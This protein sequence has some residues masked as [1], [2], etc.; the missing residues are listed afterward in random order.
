MLIDNHNRI[1][2]YLRLA[3][4]DRCNLRCQY[5]MPEEGIKYVNRG[6]LLTY[7]EML[8]IISVLAENGIQKVRITGGEPFLRKGILDFL[9]KIKTQTAIKSLHITTNG[10]LIQEHIP[11]LKEIGVDSINLSLDTI[12]KERFYK[13]TR[14][15]DLDK[16]LKTLDELVDNDIPTKI[17]MVV[18][19]GQNIEDIGPM[20][21]LTKERPVSIRFLEEMPFN[22]TGISEGMSVW[23]HQLIL[24]HITALYP[25]IFPLETPLGSTAS[26]YKIDGFKGNIGIIA[27]YSR[28]FC[29]SCDRLRITPTGDVKT[30]LYDNGRMSIK[31]ILR[32]GATD[33]QILASITSCINHRAKD[34]WEAEK[35]RTGNPI[36]ESMATIGG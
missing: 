28:T 10:T 36:N 12:D 8:R 19:N 17:N 11:Y 5:C 21:E 27:S 33:Q 6:D 30:C 2:K 7:E 31:V 23:D 29:G 1:I 13:I 4:T 32:A 16:V 3:V 24:E 22:G 18:L 25:H 14:R 15:N 9:Q 35:L 20:I 26:L 34:G